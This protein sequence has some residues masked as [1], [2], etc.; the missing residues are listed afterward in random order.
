M[1]I[2]CICTQYLVGAPFALIT[3]SIRRGME[4][5]SLWHCWGGMEAQVSLTVAFSSSAY[6][7]LLFLIFLLTIPCRFSMGFRSGESAGQSSTPTPWSFN[8]LLVLLGNVGRC[9][10]LLENEI[11]IVKKLVSRRKHEVLQH[12]FVNEWSDVGFQKTQWTN[13]SRWHCTPNHHRLWK[14]NTGLQATWAMSFSTLPPDSR[15]L[16]SKWNTKLA[17][18]WKEDFGPLG[19]SPVL[20]LLSPGKM[21]LM[22]TVAKF[23]DTSVCGALDVLTPASVHSL[24]SSPKFLNRFCLTILIMLR[25]S[26]LVEHLFLPHFF[27]PLNFLLTCLDTALCEQLLWQWMF[28]AF[29]PC[30]G[31][32]WLSSGQLSDQQSSP[33]LCSLVN[34][35]ERPFWR[36]RKPLQVFWV[37]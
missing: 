19:N 4:V 27:L 3:A 20:L 12:F 10:I 23:L 9:Q 25:F 24:W 22:T 32:Q 21:S 18:I 11:S 31:C 13:T 36:L 2:Y 14:L 8:Q 30:E 29:P 37:D 16:V 26:R 34:Q 6:F 7:G 35:T 33:W 15:T 17:L 1:F 5:I 28:V